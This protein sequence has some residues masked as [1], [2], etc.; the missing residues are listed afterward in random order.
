[1]ILCKKTTCCCSV[2]L[3]MYGCVTLMKQVGQLGGDFFFTDC[4]FFGA[5]VSATDPG[6]YTYFVIKVSPAYTGGNTNHRIT[7][8]SWIALKRA[9]NGTQAQTTHYKTKDYKILRITRRSCWIQAGNISAFMSGS[10]IFN[11]QSPT[12]MKNMS[13]TGLKKSCGQACW[14]K[15]QK[16]QK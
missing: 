11:S 6:R 8:I 1:M 13:T 10:L 12:E 4:L 16:T 15:A 14:R 2:R 9:G 5:I 3:L 7:V